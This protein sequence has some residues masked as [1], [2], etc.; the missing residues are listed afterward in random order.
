MSEI[1]KAYNAKLQE[2]IS[3]PPPTASIK[4]KAELESNYNVP[5]EV[6]FQHSN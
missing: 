5:L 4:N 3:L 2:T 6:Q 1:Q